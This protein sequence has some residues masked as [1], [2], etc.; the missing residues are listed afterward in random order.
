MYATLMVHLDV[1]RDN[2]HLL[3][4]AG[5]AAERFEAAVIG[6]T[7][8]QPIQIVYGDGYISGFALGEE[9]DD[10]EKGMKT[11]EDQ[12][13]VALEKRARSLEWRASVTFGSPSEY[14]AREA[15]SA[16]LVIMNVLRSESWLDTA[17][18]TNI[19]DLVMRIGRPVLIVPPHVE[20]LSAKNIV[21]G[22]K[23]TREARRAVTDA[24]PFLKRAARVVVIEAAD[25]VAVADAQRNV[26]DVAAWLKRHGV[27]AAALAL[28]PKQEATAELAAIA[29]REDADL[30]VAGAYGHSRFREWV[31]GGV[32]QDTLEHP[33]RCSLVSH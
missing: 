20:G 5:D 9:R 22:W 27:T 32:T 26:D 19:S 7:A 28:E 25:D 4:V 1:Y 6:I 8:C 31:L 17:R 14:V 16:D 12:F 18:R 21:V 13:R 33:G 24:L 30:I 15:R 11:L 2:S 29:T 3:R 10:L 23:D